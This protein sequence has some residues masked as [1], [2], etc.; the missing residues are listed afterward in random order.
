[1]RRGAKLS[2]YGLLYTHCYTIPVSKIALT[3]EAWSWDSGDK[4]GAWGL[5]TV[6]R[7]LARAFWN[8]TCK[9]RFDKPV[10]CESCFKSFA[11]GLWFIAKYAFIARSWWCL[12]EVR[13]RLGFVSPLCCPRW[14]SV[15]EIVN[16][17]RKE[18]DHQISI[19]ILFN[20]SEDPSLHWHCFLQQGVDIF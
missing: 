4:S 2:K 17:G 13:M 12:N 8:Q 16:P 20:R 19:I 15:S 11:S 5:H 7:Y 9:T 10:F 1:M 14:P 3:G 6:R 18:K